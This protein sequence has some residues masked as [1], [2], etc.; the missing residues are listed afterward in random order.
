MLWLLY[1]DG[2]IVARCYIGNNTQLLLGLLGRPDLLA[3]FKVDPN[4][5]D[6]ANSAPILELMSRYLLILIFCLQVDLWVL[7][8]CFPKKFSC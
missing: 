7:I 5:L 8:I 1:Y 3:V 6:V 2:V 4:R